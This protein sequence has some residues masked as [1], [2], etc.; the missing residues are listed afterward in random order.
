MC[1]YSSSYLYAACFVQ[2]FIQK[3]AAWKEWCSREPDSLCSPPPR[4]GICQLAGCQQRV[5]RGA[6]TKKKKS[7]TFQLFPCLC[8][9]GYHSSSPSS[10]SH[11]QIIICF[12]LNFSRSTGLLFFFSSSSP[13]PGSCSQWGLHSKSR[14][15]Q[16]SGN[17]AR[18]CTSL[19]TLLNALTTDTVNL[20]WH[21]ISPSFCAAE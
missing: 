21:R 18:K 2:A 11:Y 6:F 1:I 12:N 8:F 4:P 7:Q 14:G 16:C 15:K 19:D 17:L 20:L 13:S 9:H 3:T 10:P 5:K